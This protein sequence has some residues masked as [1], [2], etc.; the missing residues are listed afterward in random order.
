[1]LED[2]DPEAVQV[3]LEYLY[4]LSDSLR[5]PYVPLN[6]FTLDEAVELERFP[7][8]CRHLAS[9]MIAADKY[10]L[11]DL[12]KLAEGKLKERIALVKMYDDMEVQKNITCGVIDAVYLQ[13]D[14]SCLQECRS[15]LIKR[16]CNSSWLAQYELDDCILAHPRLGLDLVEFAFSGNMTDRSTIIKMVADPLKA[17]RRKYEEG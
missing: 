14:V 7:S 12:T 9:V 6:T 3:M 13:E 5:V 17:K 10:C 2:D 8:D 1:V 15:N 4:T 16:I 11:P